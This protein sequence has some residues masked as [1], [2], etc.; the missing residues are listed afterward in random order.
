MSCCYKVRCVAVGSTVMINYYLL[1]IITVSIRAKRLPA[2]NTRMRQG[3][4]TMTEPKSKKAKGELDSGGVFVIIGAQ[5]GD[6]GKGKLVDQLASQADIVCRCQG[7]NNAGH[8]VVVGGTMFDFHLLPSGIIH[9]SCKA[10]IGNGVVVN[11]PELF[12]EAAKMESK[13]V[14]G[15]WRQRLLISDRAHLVFGMLQEV[16]GLLEQE[17]GKDS[18]GTTR[19]GIGPAYAA[20]AGRSGLR[21]CDLLGDFEDFASR[22]K[23]LAEGYQKRFSSLNV[24][25][26]EE[27]D[28]YKILADKVRPMVCDT[29][30]YM[31]TAL[32]E[33]KKILVEGANA[34]MLDIDFGT[35]P[36]VTS[37]HCSIGGVCTGLGIPPH[38][39]SHVCGVVKAYTT[40]VGVG[41]FPTALTDAIGAKMQEIGREWGVTTGRKRR[42]GWLDLVVVKYSAVI[43]GYTSLAVMKLDVL[44]TFEELKIGVGY[45]VNDK[46]L[47]SFPANQKVLRDVEVDYVSIPGWKQSTKECRT[48]ES[49]PGSAQAYIKKI[50]DIVG[51]K[52]QW[53]GVGPS[54]D[55]IIQVF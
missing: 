17:K 18:L 5:W 22:F 26:E 40:R 13:G 7:G 39:V 53:I 28:N 2:Q 21:M 30:H 27:L 6:E 34:T 42:C 43:N 24:D 19:K 29:V 38:S 4:V 31:N 33:N 47:P 48:Y 15:S 44:D 9:E 51:V 20:K 16:D 23:M 55:S 52:V 50:E 1:I 32:A 54:R 41:Y 49:L 14:D 46:Q 25:I 12:Q 3:Q 37:S 35:Y 36:Y 10:V 8:T 11:L 45:K